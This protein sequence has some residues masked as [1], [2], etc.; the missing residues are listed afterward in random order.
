MKKL[1]SILLV[2]VLCQNINAGAVQ[3]ELYRQ[4]GS[5]NIDKMSQKEI[6]EILEDNPLTLPDNVFDSKPSCTAP[7]QTGV[8]KDVVLQSAAN[9]LSALRQIAGLPDVVLDDNLSK[10]AQYGAVIIGAMGKLSHT[11]EKPADMEEN[12]YR[13]AYEATSSSNLSAGYSI[14]KAVDVFMDDSDTR[15]IDRLGHRR[16]QLNPRMGKVGFGY[17]ESNTKYRYYVSEKVFD[18]SANVTSYD[19]IGWPSSGNF[20]SEI[21]QGNTAWSVTLNPDKYMKPSAYQVKV[22]ITRE[23]DNKKWI[24]TN[25]NNDVSG[26]FFNVETSNYG[27]NNCIIFRPQGIDKY[28]GTYIVEINGLRTASGQQVD[29]FTYKVDFFDIEKSE[30]GNSNE[31]FIDVLPNSYYFDAVNWAVKQSITTGTSS[32]TFSPNDTCTT[33]QIITFLWRAQGSPMPSIQN[34][35]S[36]VKTSDYYYNAAIWAYQNGLIDGKTFNGN[37]PC[38]RSQT[39]TYLWKLSGKPLSGEV[40]FNDVPE[41]AD[42]A[43]AVSWAVDAGITSGTSETTFSPD[44]I[45]NRANI[46]TFLYRKFL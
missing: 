21:F 24:L 7:Y 19:F 30:Q 25:E 4:S 40:N 8:V 3:T 45:C 16:W 26:S 12:F 37:T 38:T 28:E 15:N 33:G 1:A 44:N 31:K 35:F 5:T 13:Q 36:D 42:Y 23:S 14:T 32:N 11:P 20:P 43:E 27:V 39:V 22:T 2:A 17:A 41:N 34:P 6:I 9:R 46:V 10:Q 29:D 18:K